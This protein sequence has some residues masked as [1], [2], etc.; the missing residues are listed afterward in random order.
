MVLP[1][2]GLSDHTG[3]PLAYDRVYY[4]G[5][6][7]FYVPR[8]SDGRFIQ[9]RTPGESFFETVK[10]MRTLTPT[11][12]VFNGSVGALTGSNALT[13][14]V[15]ERVL[16]VHSQAN[17]DTRPHLIGGHGDFVWETGKFD[18][19]PERNLE[20][21]FIRGGSAGAAFYK[22]LQPGLY[23]YLNHNLIE[24]FEFGAVA[25]VNVSGTWNDD[26][27][28]QIAAPRPITTVQ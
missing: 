24:A 18:N 11:H 3:S 4:V 21:W 28:T 22:F 10:V 12:V 20:T 26:L 15:G 14:A 5:E 16:I 9:Y 27:M 17:R 19:P 2:N 7:D 6:Q 13:A 1:R 25:H 23:A 8:D